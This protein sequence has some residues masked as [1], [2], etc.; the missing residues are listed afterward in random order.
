MPT[1]IETLDQLLA[2]SDADSMRWCDGLAYQDAEQLL[3]K[4]RADEWAQLRSMCERRSVRWR[5][6]LASVLCPQQGK[7]AEGLLFALANDDAP[8]GTVGFDALLKIAFYCGVNANA[9]GAFVDPSIQ[10]PEFVAAARLAPHL[11]AAIERVSAGSADHFRH[12][13][14]LLAKVLDA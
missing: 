1:A 4:L 5:E 11:Q 7:D 12:K 14:E 6:C 3:F 2:A 8:E 9:D 10:I 13:F